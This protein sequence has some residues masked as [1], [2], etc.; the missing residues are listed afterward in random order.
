MAVTLL[1][2]H[3]IEFWGKGYSHMKVSIILYLVTCTAVKEKESEP[4]RLG[5]P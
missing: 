1:P 3:S 5:V 4:N 2:K